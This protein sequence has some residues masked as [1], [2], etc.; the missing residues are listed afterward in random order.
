M[1]NS[2]MAA[3]IYDN[4]IDDLVNL[5]R[6]YSRRFGVTLSF[7]NELDIVMQVNKKFIVKS[8]RILSC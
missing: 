3:I 2:L 5:R 8:L 1:K 6:V 7:F 4:T